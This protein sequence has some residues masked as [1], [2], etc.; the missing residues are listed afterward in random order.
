MLSKLSILFL[1]TVLIFGQ[2]CN[3]YDA[4]V[5]GAK[6]EAA[7]KL[8]SDV[9]AVDGA[10]KVDAELPAL[11]RIAIGALLAQ[12]VSYVA[13]TTKRPAEDV[14][15]VYSEDRM[16]AAGWRKAEKCITETN[17][18]NHSQ[19]AVCVYV[20]TGGAET[21]NGLAIFVADDPEQKETFIFYIRFDVVDEQGK[22]RSAA[23][24][25]R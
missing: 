23:G 4:L 17:K 13:Y 3:V 9:P 22:S 11:A 25:S 7:E 18:T 14:V 21:E 20:R 15:S 1:F 10:T 16:L 6:V 12:N 19:G 24:T 2:S 8:W 5:K